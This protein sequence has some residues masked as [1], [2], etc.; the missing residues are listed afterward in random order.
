M[1]P[2]GMAAG[3]DQALL[4]VVKER[5]VALGKVDHFYGPVVH[6]HVDV[7][8]IV[9]APGGLHVFAPEALEVG[10]HAARPRAAHQQ[11]ASH[12]K[13]KDDHARII[14]SFLQGSDAFVRGQV[15]VLAG[16]QIE[17]EAAKQPLVVGDVA[18]AQS[19]EG[20]CRATQRVSAKDGRVACR[21][22]GTAIAG[23]CRDRKQQLVGAFDG[24]FAV[25]A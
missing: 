14:V 23:R 17:I 11:I 22:T 15:R 20:L 3:V 5:Q 8:V 9:R 18:L 1:H 13:V 2:S 6:L 4:H 25:G 10:G 12:L 16:A 7:G 24:E 21:V 19:L